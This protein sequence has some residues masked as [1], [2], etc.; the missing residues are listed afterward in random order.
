MDAGGQK[1]TNLASLV[2]GANLFLLRQLHSV[3]EISDLSFY[4]F[5]SG[6]ILQELADNKQASATPSA[7]SDVSKTESSVAE[8]S[9]AET[10]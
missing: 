6:Q 2:Q 5:P 1:S 4:K 7:Q 3:R 9:S 10:W 8:E